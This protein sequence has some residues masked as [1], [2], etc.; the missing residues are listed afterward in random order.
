ML[1]KCREPGIFQFLHH[2]FVPANPEPAWE[3]AGHGRAFI[4][5]KQQHFLPSDQTPKTQTVS[6]DTNTKPYT[7]AL[8]PRLTLRSSWLKE[9][10]KGAPFG[11]AQPPVAQTPVFPLLV[12]FSLSPQLFSAAEIWITELI[13]NK[14]NVTGWKNKN[15]GDFVLVFF[16]NWDNSKS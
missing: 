16:W 14:N 6:F 5:N 9:E 15:K 8:Q 2:L 10:H 1:P 7:C 12:T 13:W 4:P 11:L 3:L